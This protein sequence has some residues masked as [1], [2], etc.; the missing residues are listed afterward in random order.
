MAVPLR[1]REKWLTRVSPVPE[2]TL[3]SRMVEPGQTAVS[4]PGKES[5]SQEQLAVVTAL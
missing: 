5:L 3:N 2:L 4:C 1:P